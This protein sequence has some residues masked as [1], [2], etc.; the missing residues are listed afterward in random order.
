MSATT[1][2]QK[3]TLT[4]TGPPRWTLP[5]EPPE[6][7]GDPAVL[8][9]IDRSGQV[10][11]YSG[12]VEYGQGIRH[13]FALTVADELSISPA[14]V[15]VVLADTARVPWDR[16]TTGSASM[17]T[18]GVQLRRAAATA[19]RVLIDLAAD[20]W[21]VKAAD[22]ELVDGAARA[23]SPA[24][25]LDF[26]ALLDG[27]SLQRDIPDDIGP[28]TELAPAED[29]TRARRV[30]ALE[31]VTGRARYSQDFVVPG[32]LH[33]KVIRP[34][35][36]GAKLVDI[37]TARAERVPGFVALVRDGDF[38]GVVAETEHAATY[39]LESVRVRWEE[40]R[41]DASDW[42][43]PSLLQEHAGEA[44]VLQESG[45]LDE[46]MGEADG[47][48]DG[49]YFAPYISNAQ[50]E[51]SAAVASWEDGKLSVWCGNRGPFSERAQLAGALG[52]SEGD[53]HVMTLAV[54]GSF[55][56]KTPTVSLEAARLA[57]HAGRP[58]KVAY[59]R[60]EEF[61]WSTVRPAALIEI[62]SGFTSGGKITAWDYR[63]FHAGE[64]AFRGRR[65]AMTPYDVPHTRVAVAGSVSPLQ[66]GSYRSL[67]GAV[68]HF[69]RETH[70][71]RM[72][73]RL[74]MDPAE[75]RLRNLSHPRYRRVLEAAMDRFGWSTRK[76]RD[77]VGFGLAV[78][79]DAGSY[80]A[81]CV[82]VEVRD[83]QVQVRRVTAA[84]DCGAI[85]N[86]DGVRNQVE[87]SIVMGIGSALW[88][89]VEFDGGRV[90][91][92][93]FNRYRVPRVMDTP[94][95]EVVLIEDDSNP[96]T[97]AGE[98]GIVPIAAAV[99][100]AVADATGLVIEQ[101]PIEPQLR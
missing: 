48:L 89:A 42:S 3:Y 83:Q 31:K 10:S 97:G 78:G 100:N 75:F 36:Y 7:G 21:G 101:L 59:T 29:A 79:F 93:G 63:A 77:G 2:A 96:A 94:E 92:T 43:L 73:R 88:E 15:D 65:G 39:S 16:G 30:D 26:A 45:S 34:P 46:G 57:R 68:N 86:P 9:T 69:A 25:T 76:R 23:G 38:A 60:S 37:D 70:M 80:V 61:I 41:D 14:D 87:G 58:V 6:V 67:G 28:G 33:G 24:L 44:V 5:G 91:T 51:P 90:L 99:A 81:E 85:V 53:V 47:V 74:E 17:R 95:I 35:T 54:G 27:L 22:V 55:G 49:T 8:L 19:R 84:F 82:E 40:S 20:R 66:H 18:V 13:G 12:K 64:N 62:K 50:M 52:I 98:P 4:V 71:D 1:S 11:V 56:T 32:M 72:A